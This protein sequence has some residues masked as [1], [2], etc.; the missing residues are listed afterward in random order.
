MPKGIED[1]YWWVNLSDD[2]LLDLR[3]CDLGLKIKGSRVEPWVKRLYKDLENKGL[4]FKPHIWVSD[5]WFSANGIPG[6]AVPFFVVHDRLAKLE[7]KMLVEVEGYKETDGVK[8]MRHE[9]G[10]AIDN[11]F[12]LRK[13]RRRQKLF[14][15]SSTPYPEEYSPKAYSR[16]YVVHLNSWYAQAHPDEDWAETFAVWL[17]PKSNWKKRYQN[18][19]A[20]KKLNLVDE[21]MAEIKGHTPLVRNKETPSAVS[22]SRKKLKTY[23]KN[24]KDAVGADEPFY[25]DPLIAKLFS[26]DPDF[27]SKKTAA[28]FIRQE[29]KLIC[30]MVA[31]WTGQYHYLINQMIGEVIRSCQEKKMRLTKSEKETRLD[32]VGMLT[33]QTLNYI[34]S[35][36]HRIAM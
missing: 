30:S 2:E 31:R 29:R 5:E 27:K 25:L 23:Y 21:I 20:I 35:G 11:A 6:I 3:F 32:L 22:Q 1:D 19:S 33:A 10:H 34:S 24:K 16:K 26:A 28:S 12:R 8:L 18:W 7:R 13:S 14:G 4:R 9:A 17:N 15:L 36:Q